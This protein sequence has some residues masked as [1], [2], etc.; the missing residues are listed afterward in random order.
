VEAAA[1]REASNPYVLVSIPSTV[2][3]SVPARAS[4]NTT[5]KAVGATTAAHRD[6]TATP[7]VQ[8]TARLNT[9]EESASPVVSGLRG[10]HHAAIKPHTAGNPAATRRVSRQSPRTASSTPR[11]S[12][13]AL[14]GRTSSASNSGST[15]VR[16]TGALS[17]WMVLSIIAYSFRAVSG[18]ITS[19]IGPLTGNST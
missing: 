19:V 7:T 6:L 12:R 15:V 4:S 5:A 3:P 9:I 11:K 16:S 14:S 2:G 8:P 1:D 18:M 17:S 13:G 10:V